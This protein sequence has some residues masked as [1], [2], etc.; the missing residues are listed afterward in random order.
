MYFLVI[1]IAVAASRFAAAAPTDIFNERIHRSVLATPLQFE[2]V[3]NSGVS[4]QQMF[5]G[6]ANTVSAPKISL[7]A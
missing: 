3:G 5:L 4:A 1:T 2:T 7:R 6:T